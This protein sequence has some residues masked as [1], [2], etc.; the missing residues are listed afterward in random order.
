VAVTIDEFVEPAAGVVQV[1]ATI[2]VEREGQKQIVIG[3]K[4]SMLKRIGIGARKRIEELLGRQVML[5]LWVRVTP[6]WRDRMEQ[7]AD[8]G[9]VAG[10]R[11]DS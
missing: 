7:L 9:L 10:G 5:K 1:S 6:D 11:E 4:G 2:H 8:F 3:E